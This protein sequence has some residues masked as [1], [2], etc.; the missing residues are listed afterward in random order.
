LIQQTN[1]LDGQKKVEADKLKEEYELK[2]K[3]FILN[4]KKSVS[5]K[6]KIWNEEKL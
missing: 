4:Q 3:E 5:E 2:M 1:S 6:E